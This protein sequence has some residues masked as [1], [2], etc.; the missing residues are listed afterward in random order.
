MY[1]EKTKSFKIEQSEVYKSYQRIKVNGGSAG[2]DK[3]SIDEF[4]QRLEKNLYKIW[5]RMSS[6]SYMVPAV[7]ELMI[8]K[9]QGGKRPLGI[10]TVGDRIAQGVIKDR[11][12]LILEPKFHRSSYGY[13]PGRDAQDALSQCKTNC[14]K[15]SWV[16]DL[17]I[18]GFFDNIS[19]EWMMKFVNHHTK[20]KAILLYTERWLKA[21]VEKGDGSKERGPK[22]LHKEV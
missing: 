7:K 21:E 4:E 6:G 1:E 2:I 5:N 17:D 3:E 16:V 22:V 12:E 10:P 20:D 14:F 15:Y 8:P 19:H 9:K 13:R 11:L 18:K